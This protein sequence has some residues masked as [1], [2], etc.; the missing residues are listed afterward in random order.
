MFHHAAPRALY[1]P[2]YQT[3]EWGREHSKQTLLQK[4]QRIKTAPSF[5]HLKSKFLFSHFFSVEMCFIVPMEATR[6]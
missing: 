5:K 1:E 4:T 2:L 3:P 6:E